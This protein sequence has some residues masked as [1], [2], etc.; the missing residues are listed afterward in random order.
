MKTITSLKNP[1]VQEAKG[2]LIFNKQTLA[3]YG[4]RVHLFP[5][6]AD[7]FRRIREYGLSKN[8]IVEH[9]IISSGLKEMIEGTDVFKSGAFDH[10]YASSF[11]YDE[12]G[13]AKA[14]P[15]KTEI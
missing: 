3:D 6:V 10:V 5:G 14:T 11:Y 13:V 4:A 9:Y 12:W 1:A 8:V 2:N 15:P 7:W